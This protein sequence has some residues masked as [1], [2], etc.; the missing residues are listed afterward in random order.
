MPWSAVTT[1]PVPRS[2]AP[3][4]CA[5]RHRPS[6]EPRPTRRTPSRACG[7]SRRDR[8]RRDRRESPDAAP[9]GR[10]RRSTRSSRSSAPWNSASPSVAGGEPG[11]R[12]L[13]ASRPRRTA[14][15]S[16]AD[17]GAARCHDE[18]RA[19]RCPSRA[20]VDDVVRAGDAR[21][22]ADD[23]VLAGQHAGEQARQRGCRG[24]R[25]DGAG[26]IPLRPCV[27]EE[28]GVAGARGEIR[29]RRGRRARRRSRCVPVRTTPSRRSA[30]PTSRARHR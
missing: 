23:A 21:P 4:G 9:R 1:T 26:D 17:S 2:I 29:A 18:R 20:A 5:P 24:R 27:G 13:V 11:A 7:R 3:R 6:P 22:V 28:P 19:R 30:P 25:E 14:G 8:E 16:V 15:R 12:V 10:R